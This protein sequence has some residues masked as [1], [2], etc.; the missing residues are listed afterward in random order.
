RP[1]AFAAIRRWLR[2]R[3][4]WARL[5]HQERPCPRSS[6]A[7]R[8]RPVR[9]APAAHRQL[10]AWATSPPSGPDEPAPAA[11]QPCREGNRGLHQREEPAEGGCDEL[12]RMAACHVRRDVRR[13]VP[14]GLW[15]QV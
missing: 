13:D 12:R 2:L 10:L 9:G 3:R 7:K 4:G 5:V 8:E 1:H 14:D 6:L 11:K 15:A